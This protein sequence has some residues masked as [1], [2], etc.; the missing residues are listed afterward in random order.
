MSG[1]P[2]SG[3][4]L[5]FR[6][7]RQLKFAL[8]RQPFSLW[9]RNSIAEGIVLSHEA[10]DHVRACPL[11]AGDMAVN[12]LADFKSVSGALRFFHAAV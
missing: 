7:Q 10:D 3:S 2:P 4:G 6:L 9:P 12:L 5:L 8:E 11:L 1:R